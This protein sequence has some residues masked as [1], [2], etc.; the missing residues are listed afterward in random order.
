[1][2]YEGHCMAETDRALRAAMQAEATAELLAAVDDL[3]AA[4]IECEIVSAGGTGTYDLIA[5]TAR[6]TESQAGS[7]VF[8]DGSHACLVADFPLAL[9]VLATVI[10]RHGTRV[11]LDAGRKA[12]SPDQMYPGVLGHEASTVSVSEEHASVDVAGGCTLAVGDTVELVPGYAP[13]TVNLHAAYHVVRNDVVTDVWPILARY[14]SDSG[15][16]Q[17]ADGA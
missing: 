13:T 16:E 10:S 3:A 17:A 12:V 11:I 5:A 9:T 2:G 14:S 7:Y 15:S 6:V 8:M 1:M 4:G